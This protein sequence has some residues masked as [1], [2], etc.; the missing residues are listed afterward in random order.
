ME[1]YKNTSKRM[2]A[3]VLS[4]AMLGA[5]GLVHYAPQI[6]DGFMKLVKPKYAA[7]FNLENRVREDVVEKDVRK[8]N[9]VAE[10]KPKYSS[11]N[12]IDLQD[13]LYG[14]AANQPRKVRK[15]IGKVI[16]N[17]VRDKDYPSNVHDVIF[18]KN[19]F[20]CI[21]DK[22]NKNWRQATGELKRNEYEEMVYKRCSEDAKDIL[23]KVGLDILRENE[24]VAYHDISIEKP[25]T[26]YWNSLEFVIEIEDILFYAPKK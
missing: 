7:K 8:T 13:I 12:Q 10:E 26:D 21:N 14:E 24:I 5:M 23:N 9:S 6:S 11:Q 25:N 19:A 17:R 1:S 15:A 4:T 20:S 2:K 18:E 22:K 16:L 3:W